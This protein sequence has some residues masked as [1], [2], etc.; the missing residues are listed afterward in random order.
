[1]R[2]LQ[3]TIGFFVKNPV[4]FQSVCFNSDRVITQNTLKCV[5]NCSGDQ[6]SI[7]VRLIIISFFVTLIITM[8]T[9]CFMVR[10]GTNP[11]VRPCA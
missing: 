4:I 7:F 11:F 3:E 5:E 1:M 6:L 8:K 2:N 9:V 10:Y